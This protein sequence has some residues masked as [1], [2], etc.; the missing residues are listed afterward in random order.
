MYWLQHG[1]VSKWWNLTANINRVKIQSVVVEYSQARVKQTEMEKLQS[2]VLCKNR[3]TAVNI[4]CIRMNFMHLLA[5]TWSCP[6][7]LLPTET[8]TTAKTAKKTLERGFRICGGGTK[9][10]TM[11]KMWVSMAHPELCSAVV[12]NPSI[13]CL[14]NTRVFSTHIYVLSGSPTNSNEKN[15]TCILRCMRAIM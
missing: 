11:N 8:R 9:S 1:V 13:F 14:L 12:N 10:N 15:V 6:F 3:G 5:G 2:H 4:V 7:F